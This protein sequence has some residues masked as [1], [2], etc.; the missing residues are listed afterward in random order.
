M[1]G[2]WQ[3]L[4]PSTSVIQPIFII[5]LVQGIADIVLSISCQEELSTGLDGFSKSIAN[6]S[7]LSFSLCAGLNNNSVNVMVTNV[8]QPKKSRIK[9][10]KF[11]IQRTFLLSFSV[12]CILS[13][14]YL[15]ISDFYCPLQLS[16]QP[17]ECIYCLTHCCVSYDQH[18]T[19]AI[20]FIKCL[21]FKVL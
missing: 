19:D 4:N 9:R 13:E 14:Y 1:N 3:R 17:V 11:L 7:S 20:S 5:F 6:F 8:A 18:T 12:F 16:L 15:C 21:I 2:W 10:R